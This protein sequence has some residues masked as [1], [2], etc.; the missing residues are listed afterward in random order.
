MDAPPARWYFSTVARARQHSQIP[1]VQ[2][3]RTKYG[4]ELLI[5]AA[6]VSSMPTFL[7]EGR[8]HAVAFHDILLVTRGD[9]LFF[10]DGR[11]HR[12]KPGAL[13]FT[14]PGEV[15]QWRVHGLDGACLFFTEDFLAE[16]FSDAHFLDQF[17]YFSPGRES[18][19]IEIRPAERRRFLDRF[20]AM[21]AEIRELRRDTPD[22]L[23]ALLYESL[24]LLN[25]FYLARH[26]GG[27]GPPRHALVERFR[28]LVDREFA[29]RHR[30][31]WYARELAVSPGHL[32]TL[33]RGLLRRSAGAL[34]R[35]RITLE[36]KRLLLYSDLTAAQVG[37]RL[38]FDDPAYF[39][40]FFRRE[41]GAAPAQFRRGRRR[42]FTPRRRSR[43]RTPRAPARRR[44]RRSGRSAGPASARA[45]S[46][47]R[48]A[49]SRRRP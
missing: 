38:G 1:I 10:L 37:D 43:T 31:A 2:F 14:L 23:R 34:I 41:A 20:A 11:P 3:H 12:V 48:S 13:F 9:G 40:R 32:R 16:T 19:A 27:A 26:P 15:R 42:T 47:S 8:P 24:V 35:A 21:A 18:V 4:P 46:G 17:A 22:A 30:V 25:R 6:F 7:F 44:G 39:A 5:D 33:C 28:K 29:R 45:R 49:G 36:A